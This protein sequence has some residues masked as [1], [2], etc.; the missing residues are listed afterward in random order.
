MSGEPED[1]DISVWL[2]AKL[3]EAPPDLAALIRS[4]V[5]RAPCTVH[6]LEEA[7]ERLMLEARTTA[8]DRAGALTLLA[9]DAL[10]TLA[11]EWRLSRSPLTAHH[12]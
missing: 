1:T 10:T 9:A 2:E 8:V 3:A 4:T 6:H 7:A 12:D 5:P 11:H